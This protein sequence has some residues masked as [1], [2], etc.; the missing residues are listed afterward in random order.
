MIPRV[1]IMIAGE[2]VED[3]TSVLFQNLGRVASQR[4]RDLEQF[5]KPEFPES[6]FFFSGPLSWFGCVALSQVSYG[7]TL[8][9]REGG[10]QSVQNS[11]RGQNPRQV[12]CRTDAS[13]FETG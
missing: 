12:L 2:Q 5:K 7:V 13:L 6:S 10:R 4:P 1:V 11:E 9:W 3:G 8:E